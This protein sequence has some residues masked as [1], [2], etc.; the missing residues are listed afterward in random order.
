MNKNGFLN[1]LRGWYKMGLL[2]NYSIQN[3][4]ENINYYEL[5]DVRATNF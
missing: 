3:N 1:K 2:K 5:V 4:T